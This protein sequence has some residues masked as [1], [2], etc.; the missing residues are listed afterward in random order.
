MWKKSLAVHFSSFFPVRLMV[1][2]S[3]DCGTCPMGTI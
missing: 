2:G 3:E 1:T